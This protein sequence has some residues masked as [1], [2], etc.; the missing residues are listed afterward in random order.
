MVHRW[1][2]ASLGPEL[3]EML[4]LAGGGLRKAFYA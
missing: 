1:G 2:W 3:Q 4:L